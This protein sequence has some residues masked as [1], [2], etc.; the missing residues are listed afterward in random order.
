M[1]AGLTI[2]TLTVH[3]QMDSG[4]PCHISKVEPVTGDI[5]EEVGYNL[6]SPALETTIIAQSPLFLAVAT[7]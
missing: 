4:Q 3:Q 7:W 1:V 2:Q 5:K 6:G